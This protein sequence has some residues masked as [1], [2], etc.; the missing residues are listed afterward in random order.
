LP[1]TTRATPP[2]LMPSLLL[3]GWCLLALYPV[4][5]LW[6]VAVTPAGAS[7]GAAS[8]LSALPH[9]SLDAFAQ[10]WQQLPFQ[11]FTVN[12]FLIC[13]IAVVFTLLTSVL[14][15]FPLACLPVKGKKVVSGLVLW[16]VIIP[17]QVL[18][19]PLFLLCQ[20]VG[21]T[22][23]NGYV[24]MLLGLTLP[25]WV[26]GFGIILLRQAFAQVPK[27][28]LD[29]AELEGCSLWQQLWHVALPLI[30]PSLGLLAVLTF[31]S[32]WGELLWPSLL[33]SQPEHFP[34]SVGLVQL[35]GAFSSNWRLIAAG[36]LLGTLP[37]IVVFLVAQRYFIPN[38]AAGSV[39]G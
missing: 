1:K 9:F 35:Q 28:L 29:A 25:F 30:K 24:P 18:M 10:V 2:Q 16:S 14:T 20:Q 5:W 3:L 21:L 31:M 33:I 4:A 39:K 15:A 26:S 8:F 36:T 37:V 23:G 32:A 19:I 22:E 34:L 7:A 12:S 27:A 38:A 17:F 13:G 11:Q 6:Q